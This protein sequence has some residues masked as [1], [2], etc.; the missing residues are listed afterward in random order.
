MP[1]KSAQSATDLLGDLMGAATETKKTAGKGKKEKATLTPAPDEERIIDDLTSSDAIVKIASAVQSAAKTKAHQILRR[2]YLQHCCEHGYKPDSS[3][4]VSTSNSRA[5]Y[6]AKHIK[7]FTMPQ[8]P[9]GT[10][11]DIGDLLKQQGFG[12]DV[13][14]KI[15]EKVIHEKAHLGLKKFTALTEGTPQERAL[16]ERLMALVK[17]NFKPEE[18]AMLL[19]KSTEVTVDDGWQNMAISVAL[20]SIPKGTPNR[21]AMAAANLDKL[22]TIIQPQF[23]I[24]HMVYNGALTDALK[25]LQQEEAD[26]ESV[27]KEIV[28]TNGMYKARC[29]G[30]NVTLYLVKPGGKGEEE[31]G[32]KECTNP[33]HAEASAKKWFRDPASMEEA[34][35]EFAKS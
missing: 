12:Q 6:Q 21:E 7:K 27:E 8:N 34:M 35:K 31:L 20:D 3:P 16:A 26:Q 11:A 18:L 13:V 33:G 4:A 29:K 23:V 2:L 1:R 10:S 30:K 19:E 25:R 24:S 22:Y 28:S 14:D 15:E 17:Q 32:T 5:I 9:D